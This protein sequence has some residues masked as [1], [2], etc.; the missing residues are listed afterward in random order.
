MKLIITLFLTFTLSQIIAQ[1][2]HPID[3]ELDKCT[4]ENFSTFGTVECITKATESWD[5]ELNKN[6]KQL[7]KLLPAAQQESL[8]TAQ[9]QWIKY[10]DSEIQL[11][12]K[13]Y[14]NL[15]G[16][17]WQPIVASRKL[18]IT[19]QRALELKSYIDDLSFKDD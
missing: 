8:K 4:E 12:Y 18:D 6:Y 3:A 11:L 9:I 15:E 5:K 7:Q 1:T 2:Q 13:V 16:S 19:K 17:M 10:R 14:S